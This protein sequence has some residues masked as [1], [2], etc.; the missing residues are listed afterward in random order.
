MMTEQAW[1]VVFFLALVVGFLRGFWV[2]S[3]RAAQLCWN[4][5]EIES[6]E[7]TDD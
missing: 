5:Q 2:E 6:D 4:V 1:K 3:D 7:D